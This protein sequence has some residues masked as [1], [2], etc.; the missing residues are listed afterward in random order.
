VG[1]LVVAAGAD[2]IDRAQRRTQ[3]GQMT[4]GIDHTRNDGF[5]G[6]VDYARTGAAQRRRFLIAAYKDNAVAANG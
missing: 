4:V 1:D 5:A 3:A 2:Q 6:D